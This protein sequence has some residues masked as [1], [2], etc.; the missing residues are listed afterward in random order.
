LKK[1]AGA[2]T[3]AYSLQ[4][5]KTNSTADILSNALDNYSKFTQQDSDNDDSDSDDED[6]D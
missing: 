6:W 2:T 3:G 5:A 4:E 1:T